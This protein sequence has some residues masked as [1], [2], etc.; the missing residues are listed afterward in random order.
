MVI[1]PAEPSAITSQTV[2]PGS[3]IQN[4]PSEVAS[5]GP[6]GR[7][8]AVVLN[9]NGWGDTIPCVESLHGSDIALEVVVVDNGSTDDSVE[10]IREAVPWVRLKRLSANRGFGGGM[11]AGIVAAFTAGW[12][13]EYVWLLNNDTVVATDALSQMVALAES[14]LRIGIVGCRL[15]DADGSG[16][17]QAL[18]GGALNRWLG[19]TTVDRE[20]TTR[21]CDHLVGASLLVRRS[22][23]ERIGGFDERYFFYLEDTELSVRARRAGWRLGVAHD[24]TVIHR[25]GGT[26]GGREST[27]S[28]LSDT[29]YARSVGVFVTGLGLP[30][31]ITA[32]PL[33]MLAMVVRRLARRQPDRVVP[34]IRAYLDGLVRGMRPA[35]V[36]TFEPGAAH[37]QWSFIRPPGQSD[38]PG[39]GRADP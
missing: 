18:G 30:W 5:D 36:P 3:L 37:P 1:P 8:V 13:P 33:R 10:R 19:T 38:D 4:I 28:L 14:D 7:V 25:L 12:A 24:A 27:R 11:N 35:E 26:I 39:P 16:R 32:V 20:S 2:G 15:V 21:E 29:H 6:V 34:V 9:W 31:V 22:L 17:I 23:L